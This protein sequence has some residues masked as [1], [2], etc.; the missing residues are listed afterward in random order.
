MKAS[1]IPRFCTYCGH[2]M[3]QVPSGY[4]DSS[5]GEQGMK[6]IC[7]HKGCRAYCESHGGHIDSFWNPV[8][9]VCGRYAYEMTGP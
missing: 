2:P 1:E 8:C 5:T 6:H 7:S 4:F 9:K 3:E